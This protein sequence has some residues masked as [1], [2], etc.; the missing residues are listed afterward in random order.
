VL[1][2]LFVYIMTS[3][4]SWALLEDGSGRASMASI[5]NNEGTKWHQFMIASIR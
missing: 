5:R 1:R 3:T 2:L 4:A